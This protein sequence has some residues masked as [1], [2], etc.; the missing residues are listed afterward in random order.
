LYKIVE[1]NIKVK[2]RSLLVN[3]KLVVKGEPLV[4]C[5]AT[6]LPNDLLEIQG[7]HVGD[8]G[9]DDDIHSSPHRIVIR[10][11]VVGEGVS[12]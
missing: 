4:S 7:H 6:K 2:S 1:G 12:C 3:K 5:N 8:P 10:L 11:N 9:K